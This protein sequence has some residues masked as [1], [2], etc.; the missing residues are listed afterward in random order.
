MD[1][2][3]RILGWALKSYSTFSAYPGWAE[4]NPQDW[5]DAFCE[6]T[7]SAI[8]QANIDSSD[9]RM[10]CIVG[11]THNAVLL[12]EHNLV[13]RPSIIY[14]D[15]RSLPQSV[16]LTNQWEDQIFIRTWNQTGPLWT[17]PQLIWIRENEPTLWRK[18]ARILFPKDFVRYQIS[19]SFVSDPIDP[20]GT[21]LFD[22]LFCNWIPEFIKSLGLPE[23]CFPEIRPI[24]QVVG[25]VSSA[26]ALVTG[27]RAG[28]PIVTGTTDTA[29]E[30]FGVGALR[31][32][33][34]VVKLATVGRIMAISTSPLSNPAFL[35][36]P[37]VLD[38]LWYPG[39]S[40]KFAAS[41][42]SWTRRAFWDSGEQQ[43]DYKVM[44]QI[45][46]SIPAGSGGILF[47]PYLAG[48]FAPSW[49][50]HLRA[51]FLG[52]GR[53]HTRAHFTRAVMEGV[54]F[55][56]R[57]AMIS[58]LEMGLE[59]NE[60]RLIGGGAESKL[61]SQIMADILNRE[62]YVPVGTDA[63]FGA[64]LLAGVAAGIFETTPEA[65]N[66]IIRYRSRHQPSEKNQAR[67][68]YLFEVY[69]EAALAIKEI[70]HKLHQFQTDYRTA[71][72]E[73]THSPPDSIP[74]E[75]LSQT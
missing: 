33:Q 64:A 11:V 39:T 2:Q 4:Q 32:G 20:V 58:V 44:D 66:T 3:G 51:S 45:A 12:D 60:V 26:A 53:D 67:Y 59:V 29:A 55:A 30:V 27:L 70:S 9:I 22:P 42:F 25:E 38:G 63:A 50:P 65:I 75:G 14:T 5:Y 72:L 17:W 6:T 35:N 19:S 28:T 31:A 56:L 15:I 62:I 36:Y 46:E 48:E 16:D 10:V 68:D 37:H 73:E 57:H 47:H 43:Y 18:V 7:R 24:T 34:A 1:S 61:W 52:V 41:A 54:G 69:R 8:Q 13:L 49:D 21:L 71:P 40:T 74:N 23:S